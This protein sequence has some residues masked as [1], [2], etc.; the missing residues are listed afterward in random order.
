MPELWC[1]CASA[2]TETILGDKVLTVNF[3]AQPFIR[4][5]EAALDTDSAAGSQKFHRRDVALLRLKPARSSLNLRRALAIATLLIQQTLSIIP[6]I[7][8]ISSG[9]TVLSAVS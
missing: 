9:T 8:F 5:M 7:L 1:N 4:E 6:A 3:G 2:E